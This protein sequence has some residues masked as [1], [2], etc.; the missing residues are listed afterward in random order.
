MPKT[1]F[2]G[3]HQHIVD[4]LVEARRQ[5]GLTQAQLAAKVGKDQ[6]FVSL[7]ERSQRRVDVLEFVA[8]AK[9]MGQRPEELFADVVE[10]LPLDLDA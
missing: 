9:A 7:I 1:V 6:T 5:S 10:R 4:V 3:A 8:L 2:T